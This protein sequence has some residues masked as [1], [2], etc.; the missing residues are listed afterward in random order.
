VGPFASIRD[1]AGLAWFSIGTPTK[2][3][4]EVAS[5]A[6]AA[7]AAVKIGLGLVA[8]VA[9][10]VTW[11]RFGPAWLVA[12]LASGAAF[13]AL[14]TAGR[15]LTERDSAQSV[16]PAVAQQIAQG[17]AGGAAPGAG[18]GGGASLG[19]PGGPGGSGGAITGGTPSDLEALIRLVELVKERGTEVEAGHYQL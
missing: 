11:W 5:T 6:L 3:I 18:G 10:L 8:T 2:L 17:G 13:L 14:V 1:F 15:L 16:H 9:A 4:G 12:A 19:G 7:H